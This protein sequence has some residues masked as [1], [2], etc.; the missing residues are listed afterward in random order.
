MK[1]IVKISEVENEATIM[2]EKNEDEET[3]PIID[4]LKEALKNEGVTE[5]INESK[6]AMICFDQKFNEE[7]IIAG[8]IEPKSGKNAEIEEVNVPLPFKKVKP[9]KK[10]DGGL[11]YYAQRKGLIT[12]INKGDT[13]IKKI[14]P[15][16][17]E[18]GKTVK[19]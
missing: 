2:V 13:I 3:V 9:V 14:P 10:E 1:I 7:I 4:D 18:S 17:G 8:A 12:L 15:T 19:G 16:I 11:D 5:G 6:L